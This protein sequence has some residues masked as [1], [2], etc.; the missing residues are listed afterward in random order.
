M[1]FD[2]SGAGEGP[3]E[4]PGT[5]KLEALEGDAQGVDLGCK[6]LCLPKERGLVART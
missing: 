5:G 2:G 3:A 4:L 1:L 6:G